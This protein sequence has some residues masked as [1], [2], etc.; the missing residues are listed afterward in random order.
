MGT[1]GL[2]VFNHFCYT[3]GHSSTSIIF[4]NDH[5]ADEIEIDPC[6][7]EKEE[8]K[9]DC[10]SDETTIYQLKFDYFQ[11]QKITAFTFIVPTFSVVS[12]KTATLLFDHPKEISVSFE[13]PDPPSGREI[14]IQQQNFRI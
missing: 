4:E 5:C 12:V 10:C 11:T 2:P 7:E 3:T 1:T 8:S 13:D 14:I 6:C 9:D